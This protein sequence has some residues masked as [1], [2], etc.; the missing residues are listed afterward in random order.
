MNATKPMALLSPKEFAA[1]TLEGRRSARWVRKQCRLWLHS[2]GRK[3]I[4]VA[5]P[6]PPYLIPASE[7]RRFST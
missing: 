4:A 3:G 7:C 1:D 2:K 6:C 5:W